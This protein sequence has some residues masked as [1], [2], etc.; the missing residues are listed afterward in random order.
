MW[1]CKICCGTTLLLDA[2]M[3]VS[4]G[5]WGYTFFPHRLDQG[6]GDPISVCLGLL[7]SDILVSLHP[8]PGNTREGYLWLT[9]G[10]GGDA[11]RGRGWIDYD[12]LFRQQAALNPGIQWNVIHPEL[13]ATT[14][15]SQS[16]PGAGMFCSV[17]Q[18]C[19][20][21]THQCALAQL[22]QPPT[23]NV[24]TSSYPTGR[25]LGRICSSWNDGACLYPGTCNF[26]HVCSVCFQHSHR[27]RDCRSSSRPRLGTPSQRRLAPQSSQSDQA[28]SST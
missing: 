15:L 25:S 4:M 18:E 2:T 28:R 13:Q 6:S 27:A 22:Q 11:P 19:D 8:R 16:I 17:C 14:V 24:P 23:R 5:G 12:H 10:E 26:R 1:T 7:F 3:R 9:G 21:G 20:H